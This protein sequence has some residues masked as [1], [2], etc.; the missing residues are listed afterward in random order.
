MASF[1]IYYSHRSKWDTT[2]TLHRAGCGKVPFEGLPGHKRQ[3]FPVSEEKA[4]EHQRMTRGTST[5]F[6]VCACARKQL[7]D[8]K[9]TP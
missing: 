4:A 6:K 9:A 8:L 1:I 5:Y 7:A 3:G 2:A